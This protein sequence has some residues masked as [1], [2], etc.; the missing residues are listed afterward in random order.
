[1]AMI[2][3]GYITG[4]TLRVE[5][6]RLFDGLRYDWADETFKASGWTTRLQAMTEDGTTPGYYTLTFDV[7]DE[8]QWPR[9]SQYRFLLTDDAIADTVLAVQEFSI[10]GDDL[11]AP[12]EPTDGLCTL[13]QIKQRLRM[14]PDVE[15][16]QDDIL[17]AWRL[18]AQEQILDLTG[19][20]L[21]NGSEQQIEEQ[22]GFQIGRV[23]MTRYRPLLPLS[24]SEKIRMEARESGATEYARIDGEIKDP[25]KGRV[26]AIKGGGNDWPPMGRGQADWFAW[27]ETTYPFVR[28]TY[29]VDQ[30]GSATNP[31]PRAL[32]TAC[33][34]LAVSMYSRAGGGALDSLSIERVNETYSKENMPTVVKGLLALHVRGRADV[35]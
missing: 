18:A 13:A 5:A 22:A 14:D 33:I 32:T 6:I 2:S 8:A 27:R 20:I 29:K 24:S 25:R 26:Y 30:L 23:Y 15:D 7:S 17:D 11:V 4:R 21:G 16:P 10:D 19:Y 28:L 3:V 1:M 34:E 9:S 31:I 35:I 12:A